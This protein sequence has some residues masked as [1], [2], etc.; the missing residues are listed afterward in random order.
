MAEL[1]PRDGYVLAGDGWHAGVIGIVAS[2]LVEQSGRPVVMVAFDGERG[3]G[4]G[5]S[6]D[7]FD[8]L[9][10]L[11]RCSEHLVR[12]GG[13]RAAAGVEL[14]RSSLDAF[15]AAFAAHAGETIGTEQP[16]VVERVDAVVECGE[17]GLSLA[18]SWAGSRR[19]GARTRLSA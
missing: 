8:L 13:H 9:G 19:S 7:G 1:G 12:F 17:L 15:A 16:R 18:R 3:R 11:E 10:G 4:S 14:D 5:R 6:I 2:R